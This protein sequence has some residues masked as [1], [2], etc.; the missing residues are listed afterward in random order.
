MS[1]FVL[2]CKTVMELYVAAEKTINASD[3]FL[4]LFKMY[5]VHF[6]LEL[7]RKTEM[8]DC[9][10]WKMQKLRRDGAI[11]SRSGS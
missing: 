11:H 3:P 7:C 9:K 2:L 1:R 10:A 4:Q 5:H 8:E 6:D